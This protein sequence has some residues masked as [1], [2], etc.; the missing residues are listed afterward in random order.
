MRKQLSIL[1]VLAAA[2]LVGACEADAPPKA[3]GSGKYCPTAANPK[4]LCP[5]QAPRG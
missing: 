5:L 1:L 2:V 3:P 4:A